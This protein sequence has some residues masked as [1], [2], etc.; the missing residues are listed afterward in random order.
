VF[1]KDGNGKITIKELQTVM[2]SL[3]ENPTKAKVQDVINEFDA[4]GNGTIDFPEFLTMMVRQK[5]NTDSEE[6][7][8]EALGYGEKLA[9]IGDMIF[10]AYSNDHGQTNYSEYAEMISPEA[11]QVFGETT[12]NGQT[13]YG[14]STEMIS[15]EASQDFG[16]TSY[17][18]DN[19]QTNYGQSTEIIS[20]EASPA[21]QLPDV[22]SF[23]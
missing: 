19:G 15:P 10:E 20:P 17:S 3:G 5:H 8:E 13:N 18:N 4:D 2:R 7:F 1:D 22:S 23:C 9:D 12:Y 6:N 11:S 14:E 21:F 16:E